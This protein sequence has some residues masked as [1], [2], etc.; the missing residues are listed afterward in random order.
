[1]AILASVYNTFRNSLGLTP[2]SFLNT[3]L[4]F[5]PRQAK[6]WYSLKDVIG[7]AFFALLAGNDEWTVIAD[8]A[9][10]EK[11]TRNT[12][13]KGRKEPVAGRNLNEFNVM[14]TEWGNCL[15]NRE[16]GPR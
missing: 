6:V 15:G 2:S 16:R 11:E 13:K 5:M 7:I 4:K 1:M 14:S 12:A 3:R 9:L 8:F 10:D